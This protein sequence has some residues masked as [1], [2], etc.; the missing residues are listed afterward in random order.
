MT[1]PTRL[2]FSRGFSRFCRY[3]LQKQELFE[4]LKVIGGVMTPP[5]EF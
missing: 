5:Y 3:F 2:H 4:I 1:P